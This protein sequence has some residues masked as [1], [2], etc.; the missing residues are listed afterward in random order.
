MTL[1]EVRNYLKTRRMAPLQDIALHFDM[2][3]D[4]A[5]GLLEHWIRKGRVQRHQ[6]S[7]CM[8]GSCCGGCG[9]DLK[10]IYEWL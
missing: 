5:R 10:E 3:P 6:D 1:S 8:T 2:A 9:D 4:A 7:G